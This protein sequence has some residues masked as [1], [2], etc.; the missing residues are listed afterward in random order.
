MVRGMRQSNT[1]LPAPA[2]LNFDILRLVCDRLTDVSDVLSFALTSSTLT[3]P[4]F[5]RRL[6]MSPVNLSNRRFVD[7]FYDFIFADE[8]ARAPCIYGLKLPNVPRVGTEE[9]TGPQLPI[10]QLQLVTILQAAVHLKY[11]HFPSIVDDLD[12]VLTVAANMASLR[13]LHL[14]FDASLENRRTVG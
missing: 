11:I 1:D 9:R 6:R 8:A 14:V 2:R 4:A 13:E 7:S 12:P 10:M 3:K 5:Q